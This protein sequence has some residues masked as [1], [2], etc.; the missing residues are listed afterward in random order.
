[1][2]SVSIELDVISSKVPVNKSGTFNKGN[3]ARQEYGDPAYQDNDFGIWGI[4]FEWTGHAAIYS[5]IDSVHEQ[6]QIGMAFDGLEI[7]NVQ[8]LPWSVMTENDYWGTYNLNNTTLSF[9]ERKSIVS[10]AKG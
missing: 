8:E 5:G 1:M 7:A 10:T 3:M 2:V 4:G 9:N 6:K